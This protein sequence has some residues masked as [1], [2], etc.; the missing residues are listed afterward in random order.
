MI[1]RRIERTQVI[2]HHNSVEGGLHLMQPCARVGRPILQH[3]LNDRDRAD[4]RRFGDQSLLV[5]EVAIDRR[6]TDPRGGGGLTTSQTW[7]A[8]AG[9]PRSTIAPQ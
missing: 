8:V 5:H 6:P 4:R 7:I 2:L 1:G 9:A 3:F